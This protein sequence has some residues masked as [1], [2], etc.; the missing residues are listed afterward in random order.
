VLIRELELRNN[1]KSKNVV[2]KF[3]QDFTNPDRK[4]ES[5]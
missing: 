1:G 4:P 5:K 2:G 3:V